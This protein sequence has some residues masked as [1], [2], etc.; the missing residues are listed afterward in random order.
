MNKPQEV[1]RQ[2]V[3][4]AMKKAALPLKSLVTLGLM[5]GACIALGASASSMAAH[6]VAN[7]GLARLVAGAVF[8]VGLILIVLLGAELFT[9]NN[10]MEMALAERRITALS[11]L[12][13]L[14]VVWVANLAGSVAIA[15]LAWKSGQ[16][17][18]GG[19][20]LGVYTIKV[21]AAKASLGPA[22]AICSGILCNMLVCMAIL[23]GVASKRASGKILAVWFP[24]MAFVTAG[25]E[26][27]VANMYYLPAGLMALS[28]GAM[29]AKAAAAGLD[30]S[31]LSVA[32]AARN[33]CFATIGN[34]IGGMLFIA[35]P[36]GWAMRQKQN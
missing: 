31:A 14:A 29:A 36:W 8:P 18:A 19:G 28:D 35:A 17:G 21:A 5:A 12:R 25:F 1:Y 33:I 11:L 16:W 4:V 20:A 30:T 26:H 6:S 13:N 32:G 3:A 7:T 15:A 34:L 22:A 23:G 2:Q 27:C 9:G 24:I 10:L